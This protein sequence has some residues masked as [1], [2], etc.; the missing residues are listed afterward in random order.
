MIQIDMEMPK[1]CDSCRLAAY[2]SGSVYCAPATGTEGDSK[3]VF[4]E[5][6]DERPKWCPLKAINNETLWKC[7]KKGNN[8]MSEILN[9]KI[10]NVSLTMADHGV[11]TFYV[12]V[13]GSGWGCG[14]GGYVIGKG[15]LDADDDDFQS[16]SG[17]GLVAMM[18]IMD[19]VGVSRWEDLKGKYCRVESEGWG[20][21]IHKIG[22][23][24][25]DKWFDI[26][27]FFKTHQKD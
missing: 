24:M 1:N 13:E 25:K 17:L 7:V 26:D 8:E 11:L 23:I 2:S 22:N 20:S 4:I 9:A 27:Q 12:T 14:L 19:V 5:S 21:S 3:T 10:T 6:G 15:Y 18:R 16:E